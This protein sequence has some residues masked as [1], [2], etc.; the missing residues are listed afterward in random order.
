MTARTSSDEWRKRVERWRESGLTAEQFAVEVGINAGT[1][2]FW[3]YKLRKLA[4]GESKSRTPKSASA[5][6]APFV[7]VRAASPINAGFE[8]EL[9]GGRRLRV[10]TSFDAD[11]LQR[12]LGV[13]EQK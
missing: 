7:E 2:R 10:P 8:L 11:A 5:T 4:R 9:A 6:A 1:L 3:Q 12:L 13:L